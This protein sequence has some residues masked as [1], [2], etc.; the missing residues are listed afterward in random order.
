MEGG[1]NHNLPYQK[2]KE[3]GYFKVIE[4]TF[5]KKGEKITNLKTLITGKGQ[6]QIA[7]K[8]LQGFDKK[9]RKETLQKIKEKQN[10]NT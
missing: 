3:R 2:E 6:I 8:Y 1:V 9:T 10:E 5:T 7:K 4:Q